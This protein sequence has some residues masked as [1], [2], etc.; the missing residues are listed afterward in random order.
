MSKVQVQ[1]VRGLHFTSRRN[2]FFSWFKSKKQEE[3]PGQDTKDVIKDIESGKKKNDGSSLQD[4]GR[5]LLTPSNFIGKDSERME[6]SIRNDKV[7]SIA[8]NRWLSTEKINNEEQLDQILKESW[9]SAT[10]N[11]LTASLDKTFPDLVSKFTFT[12]NLQSKTGYMVPDLQI[13]VSKTPQQFKD[14]YAKEI[15]SGRLLKFKESEPN[16]IDL[17]D[18][19][20][21]SRNVHIVPDVNIKRRNRKFGKIVQEVRALEQENLR[22]TLEEAKRA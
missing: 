6:Q 15:L 1:C 10:G 14:Y 20:Y 17:S 11:E 5:L 13:T 22:R 2:N 16:A 3:V 12:K 21:G 9:K 19:D 4:S 7:N 18:K 8:F